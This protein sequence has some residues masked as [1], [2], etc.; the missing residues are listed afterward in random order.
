M[1]DRTSNDFIYY[2]AYKQKQRLVERKEYLA[3][4]HEYWRDIDN[5]YA[6]FDARHRMIAHYGGVARKQAIPEINGIYLDKINLFCD[7]I[8]ESF[9]NDSL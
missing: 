4:W 7:L 2:F 1:I 6:Y 5:G 9:E 8:Q 3:A